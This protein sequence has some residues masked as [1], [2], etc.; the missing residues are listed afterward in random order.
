LGCRKELAAAVFVSV[1]A[2]QMRGL[3]REPFANLPL[4]CGSSMEITVPG[5]Q[6]AAKS[7]NLC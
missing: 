5:V 3:S 7:H 6:Q 1:Q 4:Q 2:A